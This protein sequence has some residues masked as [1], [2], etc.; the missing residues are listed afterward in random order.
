MRQVQVRRSRSE[1]RHV[2]TRFPS[3]HA[4]RTSSARSDVSTNERRRPRRAND[5][6]TLLFPPDPAQRRRATSRMTLGQ[7]DFYHRSCDPFIR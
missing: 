3:T 6:A 5:R 1:S 4:T 7:E 2:P